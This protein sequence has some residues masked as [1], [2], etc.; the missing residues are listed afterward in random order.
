MYITYSDMVQTGIFLSLIHIYMTTD[1][2]TINPH[3][4]TMS[5]SGDVIARTSLQLYRQYPN[6]EGTSFEYLPE[7]AEK[8]PEQTDE[9]G[10]VW[11]IKIRENAKWENGDAIDVDDVIYSFK[12]CLDPI[13]VSYTHLEGS[14]K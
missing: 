12:M 11:H 4:Y 1:V 5:V 6:A 2:D 10:K 13:T 8:E 14:G 3:I 7:L 9:E